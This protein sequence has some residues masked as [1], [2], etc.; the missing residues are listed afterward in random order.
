[1]IK[2][3]IFK[4][5]IEFNKLVASDTYQMRIRPQLEDVFDFVP[6]QFITITVGPMIKRSYSIASSP[7]QNYIDLI[8][9]T[10][11]GGPGSKFFVNAKA[12]QEVELLGPLGTFTCRDITKPTM[13][14]ATGTGI[15]PFL[16]MVEDLLINDK[17]EQEIVLNVGFRFWE[18]VVGYEQLK[19]LADKYTN[20]KYNLYLSRPMADWKGLNGHITDYI[21]QIAD[22]AQYDH[23]LCGAK[24]MIDDVS[25]Q[26]I[27]RGAA[28]ERVF[29]EKY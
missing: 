26:L 14:W 20:F 7:R 6:G 5:L 3:R 19:N 10:K 13:F 8:A 16:S 17:R 15:V 11:I 21:A 12:G 4:G 28:K 23:Y 24:D 9:D 27:A 22:V 18:N 29:Y 25:G 2:P 1:M